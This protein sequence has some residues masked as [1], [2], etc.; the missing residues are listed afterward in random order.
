MKPKK[1]WANLGVKDVEQTR[2]FYTAL[3]FTRNGECNSEELV[4]FFIGDDD[5]IVHFFA[6][7]VL[8]KAIKGALSDLKQGNE[9]IFTLSAENKDEVDAW[10]EEVRN[11]GGKLVSEPA[12]F[13]K[14]YYGFDFADPDGHKWN[15]FY[16]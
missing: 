2:K 10:A 11:A 16:M 1:I 8:Q 15:V 13:G 9:I 12:E 14:G 6:N 3:G 5:F 4:S 7:D